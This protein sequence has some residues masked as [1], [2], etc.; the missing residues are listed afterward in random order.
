MHKQSCLESRFDSESRPPKIGGEEEGTKVK[1][2]F[3]IRGAGFEPA[4]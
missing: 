1:K 4:R 3:L 2:P